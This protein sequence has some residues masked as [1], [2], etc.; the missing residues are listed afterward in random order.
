MASVD[1]S[2]WA[3]ATLQLSPDSSMSDVLRIV[4]TDD[5]CATPE[6]RCAKDIVLAMARH[7]H[8][9]RT[10]HEY[11]VLDET[12]EDAT[13]GFQRLLVFVLRRLSEY[14]LKRR[15]D[16][17]YARVVSD[18]GLVTLAWMRICSI[19]EFV[20]KEV[21]KD[22][23]P[24]YWKLLVHPKDHLD[25]LCRHLSENDQYAEFAPLPVDEM[26][27]SW[28]NGTYSMRDNLFWPDE[29]WSAETGEWGAGYTTAPPRFDV[30]SFHR[31]DREFRLC[32]VVRKRE[33]DR[34]SEALAQIGIAQES[35]WWLFVLI[36]RLFFPLHQYD[37]WQ[38]MPFVKTAESLDN[39]MMSIFHDLFTTIL[40]AGAVALLSS[41]AN[42]HFAL[43][44]IVNARIGCLLMRDSAPLEQGDWQSATCGET[45]CVNTN[46]R[47]KASFAH[48]WKGNLF[49]VG[50]NMPYKNDAATVERRVIMFDATAATVD[51]IATLR[52]LV[53]ANVDLLMRTAVDAYLTAASTHAKQ[54]V[55]DDGVMPL[56]LH[57]MRTHLREITSPLYSCLR[58]DIFEY[59]PTNFMPLSHFKDIY[60][61]Y[62]RQRGLQA[63]RWI[64]DHWHATFQEL[65]LTLERG[66]REYHGEK[67]T[68]EWIV[69]VDCVALP[70]DRQATVIT[71]GGLEDLRQESERC[72]AEQRRA[73]AR[74]NAARQ[75][76][77]IEAQIQSLKDE[78]RRARLEYW[79]TGQTEP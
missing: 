5:A 13:T 3:F 31:V 16:D 60:Q 28:R 79:S 18:T 29:S 6:R 14:G 50:A 33:L 75:L 71:E 25:V 73:T 51:A 49:A 72:E 52:T 10:N 37:K 38:V 12:I 66:A 77:D 65:E 7:R 4:Y 15:D 70:E 21:R 43:E 39:A 74:Y 69:G 22:V 9:V 20:V 11:A 30:S 44:A 17:C 27:V 46:A 67:S 58:S 68:T 40:G 32:D 45:V 48:D 63:Q 54:S 8:L 35:H 24:E 36:G 78:R 42:V 41:G 1:R 19:R 2:D 62:R 23:E 53:H 47:G 55:W 76:C 34:I 57:R 56:Y 64:R 61:D 59:A 26:L